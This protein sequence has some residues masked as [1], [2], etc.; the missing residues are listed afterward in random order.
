MAVVLADG[1]GAAW[2]YAQL[3]V[4]ANRIAECLLEQGAGREKVIALAL[5][6]SLDMVAAI[7]AC[8]KAGAAFLPIDPANPPERTAFMLRD[9]AA[10]LVL[11]D[12]DTV[13]EA[14]SGKWGPPIVRLG[15]EPPR[16]DVNPALTIAAG[17]LAYVIYTSGSTGQ[18]KG[19]LIE[20]GGLA[21]H[22]AG[23]TERFGL[24]TGDRILQFAAYTFDQGLEQVL[25]ALTV[26]GTL[27]LR[28]DDVWP[29]AD[30]PAVVARYGV[31][32]MNLP[33]AYWNQVLREWAAGAAAN[34][35]DV[36]A[37]QV[38]T[39]ISGGDV[40]SAESLRLWQ[41]TPLGKPG[42]A[43]VRL[44]NAYGPTETT[45]TACAFD[46][47]GDWRTRTTRPVP[48]G[49]PLANRVAYIVD[50]RGAPTP[51]G[52]P[53]ELWLG[54]TGVGR[55]YLNRDELTAEKFVA[56][57]FNADER[58]GRLYRTGDLVRYLRDGN[59]EFVGR[60]DEQVKIRGFRIELGEIEAALREHPAV[61]DA[62]VIARDDSADAAG[63]EK[64]LVAY[65]SPR[66]GQAE[67][68]DARALRTFVGNK[69]PPYMVPVAFV[70]L[71][72]LPVTPSGKV[73]RNALKRAP[74]PEAD[75]AQLSPVDAYVGPRTPLEAEI[76]GVWS[77]VLG[78]VSRTGAPQVG[79]NDNF[80]DIGGHSLLATQI[81]SRLRSRYPVD[82]PLRR[83][84]EAPTV[85][86]LA[87]LIEEAL[88]GQQSD[89]ELAALLAELD[90]AG[91]QDGFAAPSPDTAG[92]GD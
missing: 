59:I 53:G 78:S 35:V 9:S 20:H 69:L 41:E 50:P 2:T 87:A 19:V 44:I 84:F 29:P 30:F 81:V 70:A 91:E 4:R 21:Q 34:K 58:I 3:N 86:G 77:E 83:L 89:D 18:P 25:A 12:G 71:P 66:Q 43:P 62:A 61:G 63:S 15:T 52:V 65:L 60:I 22:I 48:I 10:V 17:D 7:W 74:L 67:L 45:I 40:L 16:A 57:P 73:D 11:V 46:T 51:I 1:T 76:A 37:G 32:V 82:L 33:P 39:V 49:R 24:R 88:L 8:L 26:G 64:R 42:A 38:R 92:T 27:V 13:L 55:G 54:G 68:L 36:P 6:R 47:P 80:F 5:H 14:A 85:S 72:A 90:G 75:L 23:V 56:N 28:G 79:M 31:N